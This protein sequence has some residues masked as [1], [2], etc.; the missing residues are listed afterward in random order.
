M[1]A[2]V[3]EGGGGTARIPG[4]RIGGKTGTANKVENGVYIDDTYSSFIGMAPMDDPKVAILLVVDSPQ[5]VQYGSLTAAPGAKRILEDTLRYMNV[6][7]V[8]TEEERTQM[9]SRQTAVPQV[10]GESF[11]EAAGIL[12]GVELGYQI[13][14]ALPEGE[15]TEDFTIVDQYPKPG[16]AV[17]KGTPVVLYWE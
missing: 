14:P 1:E 17:D 9:E 4:Y 13:S 12:G 15:A 7:K 10:T 5:G 2:V 6:E 16:V 8:Y 3:A 11:S